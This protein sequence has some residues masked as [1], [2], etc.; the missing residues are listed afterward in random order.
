VVTFLLGHSCPSPC[1]GAGVEWVLNNWIPSK[2]NEALE[3][4]KPCMPR[5]LLFL[6]HTDDQASGINGNLESFLHDNSWVANQALTALKGQIFT[7]QKK[8]V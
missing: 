5:E 3:K 8:L 1:T 6:F 7:V 4:H 2:E